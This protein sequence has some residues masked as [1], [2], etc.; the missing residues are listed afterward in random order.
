[1][2]KTELLKLIQKGEQYLQR[3]DLSDERRE[4]AE[5][6]YE[7]LVAQL[8]EAEDEEQ[9]EAEKIK[10]IDPHVL[11]CMNKIRATLGMPLLG[12]P[13]KGENHEAV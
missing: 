3:D 4:A 7:N 11:E 12:M 10:A 6:R 2:K 8:A 13:L 5:E 9:A 1:M